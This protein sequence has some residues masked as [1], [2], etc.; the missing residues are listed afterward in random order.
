M[1]RDTSVPP[2]AQAPA[3]TRR[4]DVRRHAS[5]AAPLACA[6]LAALSLLVPS[7]PTTDPWGWI[8]WGRELVHFHL[9]TVVGGVPSWKPLPVLVTTPLALLGGVAPQLWLVVARAGGLFSLFVAYRLGSRLAGPW[10]GAISVA[11]LVLSL[12]WMRSFGHGYTE[13]LAIG[14]LLL[15]VERE[16]DDRPGQAL[17]LGAAVTLSRP[18]AWPLLVAY[19]ALLAWRRRISL[20]LGLVVLAAAPVL[21]IVPDWL[22][23]G[24]PFHASAVADLVIPPRMGE[25]LAD[26]A[27]TP[28]IPL[29]LAA[30]AGAAIAVRTRDRTVLA[31]S[32][33]VAAWSLLLVA[34][35]ALGYPASLR[36]FAIPAGLVAVLGAVGMVCLVEASRTAVPRAVLVV[37][38][39]A[40]AAPTVVL[41]TANSME[42][43]EDTITRARLESDLHTLLERAG[44]ARV[45]QCG[46]AA[47]P[48]RLSWAR[49]VVAWD[50]DLPLGK[51]HQLSTSALGYIDELSDLRRERLPVAPNSTVEVRARGAR[52]VL[53]SPFAHTPVRET[54]TRTP[55]RTIAAVGRWRAL[56]SQASACPGLTTPAS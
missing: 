56:A 47:F 48:R 40:I 46:F 43:T 15:A 13:P 25:A 37:A 3:I 32:G 27:R 14:L 21:W 23:S 16:L 34:M 38:V 28:P 24:D 1:L 11:G 10:A 26:A 39:V 51:V 50:L 19:A 4:P 8:L 45:R 5:W 9:H 20:W 22:S 17:V 53:F 29:S 35:M 41:R 6:G 2:L 33:L 36:F 7:A 12:H 44:P 49:G 18:E 30:V 54:G 55:M 42:A 52:F 31:L